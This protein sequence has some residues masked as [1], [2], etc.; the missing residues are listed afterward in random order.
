MTRELGYQEEGRQEGGRPHP[1]MGPGSEPTR[2]CS[3]ALTW[4]RP[5]L[6]P[7]PALSESSGPGSEAGRAGAVPGTQ[8][9][10]PAPGPLAMTAPNKVTLGPESPKPEK[11]KE[12]PPTALHEQEA[13]WKTEAAGKQQ[14][15]LWASS[16]NPTA[17]TG[18]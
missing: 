5:I 13:K 14:A 12:S 4:R 16:S 15:G 8:E 3:R 2:A 7:S 10:E 11:R 18:P 6:Q 9:P 17:R 1:A